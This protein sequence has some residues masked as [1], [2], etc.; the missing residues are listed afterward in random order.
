M[1]LLLERYHWSIFLLL[2]P[3][4]PMAGA[5][6][7]L[8]PCNNVCARAYACVCTVCCAAIPLPLLITASPVFIPHLLPPKFFLLKLPLAQRWFHINNQ[9]WVH[10]FLVLKS[11]TTTFHVHFLG[12]WII[13]PA[14]TQFAVETDYFT[15]NDYNNLRYA[16]K[17]NKIQ[18]QITKIPVSYKALIT[19]LPSKCITYL[20][21]IFM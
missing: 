14:L 7:F 18:D 5:W 2:P 1:F 17:M 13:E 20:L 19:L 11:M 16:V 4:S 3:Q 21:T 9:F 10:L 6:H 15:W 8:S 12:I